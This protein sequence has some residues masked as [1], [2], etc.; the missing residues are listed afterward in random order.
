MEEAGGALRKVD[1][2][3]WG[4]IS[5]KDYWSGTQAA[6]DGLGSWDANTIYFITN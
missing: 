1:F 2:A 5:T 6:Y 3:Y 4:S